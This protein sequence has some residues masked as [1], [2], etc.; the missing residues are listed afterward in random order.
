MLDA[1]V[2]AAEG[3]RFQDRVRQLRTASELS[4]AHRLVN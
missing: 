3:E 4:D 2:S 1:L